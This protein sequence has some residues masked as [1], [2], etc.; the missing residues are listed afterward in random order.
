MT[1]RM[2]SHLKKTDNVDAND[3]NLTNYYVNGK[4]VE[5]EDQAAAE[6]A[7]VL[8]EKIRNREESFHTLNNYMDP[9]INS[10]YDMFLKKTDSQNIT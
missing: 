3:I 9:K 10:K 7:Q 4:L 1:R 6:Y 2:E 5:C 8:Y